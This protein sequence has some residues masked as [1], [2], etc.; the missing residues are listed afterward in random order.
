[1]YIVTSGS[2][3]LW[4]MHALGE[5]R[6]GQGAGDRWRRGAH[7]SVCCGA[8]HDEAWRGGDGDSDGAVAVDCLSYFGG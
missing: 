8:V 7:A 1:M 6:E 5:Q 4:G 3:V 2:L